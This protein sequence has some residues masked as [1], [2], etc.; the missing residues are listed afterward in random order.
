MLALLKTPPT[1]FHKAL[2]SRPLVTWIERI[3]LPKVEY[4]I[5]L[6]GP[7]G[8]SRPMQALTTAIL[9]GL[10]AILEVLFFGEYFKEPDLGIHAPALFPV[11]MQR[12][13]PV[14]ELRV[15]SYNLFVRPPGINTHGSDFKDQ[16][17]DL[18][19]LELS[20]YDIVCLQELFDF[21]SYR[22][23]RF[24]NRA[25]NLGF[26]YEVKIPRPFVSFPPRLIDGGL[27]ILS[28]FPMEETGYH[29]YSK[30]EPRTADI[31]A[32]KGVLWAKISLGAGKHVHVFN[33]HL[34]AHDHD[35]GRYV[36]VRR[37]QLQEMASF[38]ERVTK[39]GQ[40]IIIAGDF[41]VNSRRI[42]GTDD[43]EEYTQAMAILSAN[44]TA[45]YQDV[46]KELS[47][48]H[49]TTCGDDWGVNR[50]LVRDL[51]IEN[52]RKRLDYV[53]LRPG[54]ETKMRCV[55]ATVREFPTADDLPFSHLS[56]H[57]AVEALMSL[58]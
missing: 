54:T 43:S 41:N 24:V 32:G 55:A 29:I 27:T 40:P 18:F 36:R 4:I 11:N 47:G 9:V 38:V 58:A 49:V 48:E 14:K 5:R 7:E 46:L 28:R 22:R 53:L 26:K 50:H 30:A 13:E 17:L 57:F 44:G 33:T 19:A 2:S 52:N 3:V 21:G 45:A 8:L 23:S 39:D 15:L 35:D 31:L 12:I 56:D 1:P 20:H 6:A 34:Q 37:H 16:R 42:G 51:A 25:K 10:M